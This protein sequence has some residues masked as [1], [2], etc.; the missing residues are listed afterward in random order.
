MLE[1]FHFIQVS[2]LLLLKSKKKAYTWSDEAEMRP[3]TFIKSSRVEPSIR[4]FIIIN[5]SIL[6]DFSDA[7]FYLYH[8]AVIWTFP[9]KAMTYLSWN[10]FRRP[11]WPTPKRWWF[12][13]A[14]ALG[15]IVPRLLSWQRP[16]SMVIDLRSG[17]MVQ[18]INICVKCCNDKW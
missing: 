11:V 15:T 9:G 12:V 4:A 8:S 7:S 18:R 5:L 2:G 3:L 16:R 13:T 1:L 17:H 10:P 6:S 14:H